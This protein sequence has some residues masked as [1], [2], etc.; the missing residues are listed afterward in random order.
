MKVFIHYFA[1]CCLVLFFLVTTEVSGRLSSTSRRPGPD[2]LADDVANP[3]VERQLSLRSRIEAAAGYSC[4]TEY[5]A[6]RTC[7]D[8]QASGTLLSCGR[9]M[10][11]AI[12]TS[13]AT[14]DSRVC[15]NILDCTCRS[16]S[17]AT[18]DLAT[19]IS[20]ES[21]GCVPT[22]QAFEAHNCLGHVKRSCYCSSRNN[23][24]CAVSAIMQDCNVPIYS[25]QRAEYIQQVLGN[26]NDHCDILP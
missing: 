18:V 15:S 5:N 7:V 1:Y 19:C 3:S 23:G 21:T 10:E 22:C 6:W 11:E 8:N 26:W 12:P 17:I 13:Q 24:D 4:S 2:R 9:C 20:R 14:C 16:C 25:P